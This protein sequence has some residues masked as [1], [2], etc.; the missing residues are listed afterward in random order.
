MKKL[1]L[2]LLCLPLFVLSQEE[3]EYE[4]TMSFS[5]FAKE[6]KIAS[7]KKV[8]YTLKNC[9]IVANQADSIEFIIENLEFKDTTDVIIQDC[10]FDKSIQFRNSIFHS[11]HF[12]NVEAKKIVID[13]IDV[14]NEL[15]VKNDPDEFENQ[16]IEVKN[17][18]IHWLNASGAYT[19]NLIDD[20][21]S[22]TITGNKIDYTSI[23][24]Y[25]RVDFEKNTTKCLYV[26]YHF[27]TKARRPSMG[28]LFIQDNTV[29]SDFGP[30]SGIYIESLN[31]WRLNNRNGIYISSIKLDLLAIT[32]NIFED[33]GIHLEDPLEKIIQY[34]KNISR[35]WWADDEATIYLKIDPSELIIDSLQYD[36]LWTFNEKLN[37]LKELK[38]KND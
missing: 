17:S 14:N 12:T 5:Q 31:K 8:G 24:G 27:V 16:K 32:N 37:F 9:M 30:I 19:E 1:I 20:I 23:S 18:V 36:T 22:F 29:I 3:R 33:I 28:K 11:L 2:I 4:K 6:L 10:K 21:S 15:V 38:N 35:F 34:P 7:N 26:G 13:S 25:Y